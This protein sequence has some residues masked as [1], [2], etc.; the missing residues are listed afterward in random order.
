MRVYLPCTLR[1]V[2]RL[3]ADAEIGPPP[4]RGY[5]VTPALREWYSS[6]DQEELEYAAMSQAARASLR[7]LA[8]DPAAPRRRTVLTAELPAGQVLPQ[9][10]TREAG[11]VEITSPVRLRDIVCGHIDDPDAADDV[12]AAVAALPAADDGDADAAFT[13]GSAE[14]HELM[15]YATQELG[16]E[17]GAEPPDAR[18]ADSGG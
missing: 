12:A 10:G 1:G 16:H 6:G 9:P 3:F 18:A 14:G 15:W 8:G 2:A 13:V 4:V 17:A 11:L 5:A 7:L